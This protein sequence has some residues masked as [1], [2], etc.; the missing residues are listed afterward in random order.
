MA[1]EILDGRALAAEL[2]TDLR[3]RTLALRAWSCTARLVVV[4]VG[5][6]TASFAYMR[7]LV[8]SGA[9]VG[10]E[11]LVRGLP[12][13]ASEAD[14]RQHLSALGHDS[15]VHG[16][17]LQQPLPPHLAIRRITDAMPPHKVVD[18]ANPFN[19]GRR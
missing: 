19:Q 11:V 18:G 6:D 8:K 1:A 14:V 7:S 5:E 9:G 16:V 15:D 17:I 12:A 10:V 4:I 2:R 13:D 3:A